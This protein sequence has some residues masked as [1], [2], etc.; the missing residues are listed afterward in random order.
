MLKML[1]YKSELVVIYIWISKPLFHDHWNDSNNF[2]WFLMNAND[3]VVVLV[4][5]CFV[6]SRLNR[7]H[8]LIDSS[9]YETKKRIRAAL[10]IQC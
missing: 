6:T 5:V 1:K 7:F 2:C 9:A 8:S 3:F 10:L 4:A